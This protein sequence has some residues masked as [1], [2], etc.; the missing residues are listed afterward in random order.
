MDRC[1]AG[2]ASCQAG[3]AQAAQ[4]AGGLAATDE[5][6]GQEEVKFIHQSGVEK[7]AM[8]FGAAFHQQAV[9]PALAQNG[10]QGCKV[11]PI[12]VGRGEDD[13]GA[14]GLDGCYLISWGSVGAGDPG[15][16]G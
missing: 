8:N 11:H 1:R 4:D 6:W 16:G 15:G 9:D 13:L 7:G 2:G 3:N 10:E 5:F 12:V 14:Q